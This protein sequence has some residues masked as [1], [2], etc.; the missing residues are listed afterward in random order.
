MTAQHQEPTPLSDL[1]LARRLEQAEGAGCAGFVETRARVAPES[2]ACWIEVAGA[3]TM[4]DGPDSPVTQTFGL[5]MFQPVTP[6]DLDTI[7]A[8]YRERGAPVFH[9]VSPL[10]GIPLAELLCRRGYLPVEFSSVMVRPTRGG[11]PPA[12]PPNPAIQVRRIGAGEEELWARTAAR[13]WSETGEPD[14]MLLEWMRISA[15]NPNGQAFLAELDGQPI[16][17][18]FLL[19]SEWAALLAGASTVPE[20][21]RQGAQSALL[22]ARLQYAADHGSDLAMMCAEPGSASQRNAERQG[23]RI[24]YTRTKWRL[25]G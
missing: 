6:A 4:F 17:A 25:G 24:A 20:A 22:A 21:R 13:G 9:E 15:Q 11:P 16:A 23:F 5:G 1:D 18:G 14:P 7:E 8:F 2:G 3:R 12:S 19:L 10:A